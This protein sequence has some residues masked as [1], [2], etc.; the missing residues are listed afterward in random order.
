MLI[1]IS[2]YKRDYKQFRGFREKPFFLIECLYYPF[3]DCEDSSVFLAYLIKKLTSSEVVSIVTKNHI[4][5]GIKLQAND[6]NKTSF[7]Y[8]NSP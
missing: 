1:L 3:N 2:N 8:N 7:Y 6:A 4:C 5:L